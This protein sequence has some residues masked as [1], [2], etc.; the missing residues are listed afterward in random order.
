[1]KINFSFRRNTRITTKEVLI[2]DVVII[3]D[4]VVIVEN[5]FYFFI[6]IRKFINYIN[7]FFGNIGV[8]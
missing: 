7:T 4:F 6:T 1:M 5:T 3:S 8:H 2:S